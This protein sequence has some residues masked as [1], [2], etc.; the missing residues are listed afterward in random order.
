V[1]VPSAQF[2]GPFQ[3]GASG[4]SLSLTLQTNFNYRVQ[5]ATNLAGTIAWVDLTNFL[6]TNAVFTFSDHSATNYRARFYRLVSP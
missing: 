3:S 6:A 1:P 2:T 5:A 4:F